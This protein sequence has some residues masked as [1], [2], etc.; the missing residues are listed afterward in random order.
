[1]T[2][3]RDRL[4]GSRLRLPWK[5]AIIVATVMMV[6]GHCAPRY[7]SPWDRLLHRDWVDPMTNEISLALPGRPLIHAGPD[8]EFG[9]TDDLID[10]ARLGDLDLVLRTGSTDPADP[11]PDPTL[12]LSPPIFSTP[13]A[14]GVGTELAFVVS[15]V[16]GTQ[17][18]PLDAPV[19]SE[20]I[21]GNPMLVLAFADLDADGRIGP[22]LEDGDPLD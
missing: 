13:S 17:P 11:I 9:T 5:A 2:K 12:S 15:A 21:E 7:Y 4:P 6:A 16:D 3:T 19:Q 8:G 1:M 14:N 18:D 20:S 22:T 10:A